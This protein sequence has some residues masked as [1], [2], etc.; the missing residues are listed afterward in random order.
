MIMLYLQVRDSKLVMCG[1]RMRVNELYSGARRLSNRKVVSWVNEECG[2]SR[3]E[4]SSMETPVNLP[5]PLLAL[6]SMRDEG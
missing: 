1:K 3:M 2:V 4:R 6:I 5:E